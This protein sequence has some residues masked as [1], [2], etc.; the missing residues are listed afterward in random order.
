VLDER[1]I[2]PRIDLSDAKI[3]VDD[4]ARSCHWSTTPS[5][6]PLTSRPAALEAR[7]GT[8]VVNQRSVIW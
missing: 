4:D 2:E 6:V 7:H 3:P 8:A 1:A 5:V